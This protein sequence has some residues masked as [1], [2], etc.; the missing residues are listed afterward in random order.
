MRDAQDK[1][2]GNQGNS[3]VYV[4]APEKENKICKQTFCHNLGVHALVTC[5]I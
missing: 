1:F 2:T 3:N 5:F 4:G